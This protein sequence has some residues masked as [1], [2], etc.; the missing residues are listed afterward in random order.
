MVPLKPLVLFRH[1]YTQVLFDWSMHAMDIA[2]E[3]SESLCT[4]RF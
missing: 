2:L 3:E 1:G 4:I